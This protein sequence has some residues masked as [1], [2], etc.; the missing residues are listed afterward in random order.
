MTRIE[1][2][3]RTVEKM[4]RLYC[5][6]KEGNRALCPDCLEL[7][8]YSTSRLAGCPFGEGKSSC[9]KCTVH[10]YRPDMKARIREVM[11]FSGPRMIIYHPIAAIRHII[12]EAH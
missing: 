12:N 8:A 3:K 1:R 2:E 5:R 11:R 10:C 9:R 4:I 7:L 6:H